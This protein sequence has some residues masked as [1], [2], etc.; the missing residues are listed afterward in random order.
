MSSDKVDGSPSDAEVAEG[1]AA[2]RMDL[3]P[4]ELAMSAWGGETSLYLDLTWRPTRPPRGSQ[5]VPD[6]TGL[7]RE[8]L[9]YR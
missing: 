4:E 5:S 2:D 9:P 6:L 7:S 8:F 3:S 1:C